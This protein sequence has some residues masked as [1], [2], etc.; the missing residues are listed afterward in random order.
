M[1]L[2]ELKARG[3]RVKPLEWDN[4]SYGSISA[5]TAFGEY[6]V[7][8]HESWGMWTPAE[9]ESTSDAHSHY[10]TAAAAKAAAEADHAA[11]I[12]A[13]VEVDG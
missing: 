11:R 7:E 9:G 3:L 6:V 8:L 10:P 12:A 4:V 5:Q 2:D 1:T 13:Q